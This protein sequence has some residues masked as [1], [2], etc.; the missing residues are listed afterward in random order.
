MRFAS[1]LARLFSVAAVVCV[2]AIGVPAHA[3]GVD[4]LSGKDAASGLKEA[5]LKGADAAIGQ[6]GK[7]DGFLGDKRVK[8]PLPES[9][10][11]AE[12]MMRTFGMKK[13]A[14]EL[15]ETMNRAAELAVVEAKPILSN[16]RAEH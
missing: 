13:Q 10:R 6:L 2:V 12:K 5:L 14:D 8:I 9:A 7:P 3:A 4:Q 1:I 11:A 15:I 16:A